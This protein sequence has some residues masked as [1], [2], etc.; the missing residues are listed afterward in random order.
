MSLS[1]LS[2]IAI[3]L[4]EKLYCPAEVSITECPQISETIMKKPRA[5]D[6]R[7]LHSRYARSLRGR[8][9]LSPRGGSALS[10]RGRP[11]LSPRGEAP[12][13][14]FREGRAFSTASTRAGLPRYSPCGRGEISPLLRAW[15]ASSPRAG[16]LSPR[17]LALGDSAFKFPLAGRPR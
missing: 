9:A 11:V 4:K 8:V 10:P 6:Y 12:L 3:C 17:W 13:I 16:A 7:T 5:W 15:G 1:M 14:S 2:L